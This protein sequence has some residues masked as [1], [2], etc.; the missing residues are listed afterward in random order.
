M[1]DNLT[2]ALPTAT[3]FYRNYV[4]TKLLEIL[5]LDYIVSPLNLQKIKNVE[6]AIFNY[7]VRY[8]ET[9]NKNW[10]DPAFVKCYSNKARHILLNLNP[11]SYIH[12]ISLLS[13]YLND[14][15]SCVYLCFNM[16]HIEMFP[17][18]FTSALKDNLETDKLSWSVQLDPDTM[19]DGAQQC[20]KC[21]SWKTIYHS[22]QRRSADEPESLYFTCLS[23]KNNW[24]FG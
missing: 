8:S 13:R 6:I 23:C 17:E 24:R 19:P 9:I 18:R 15:F 4:N 7:S 22:T 10:N 16:G 20:R 12:N 1:T 14:E 2:T 11:H 3:H 21:R 5:T